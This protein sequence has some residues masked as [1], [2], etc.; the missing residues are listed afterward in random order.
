[1]NKRL[2]VVLN[3]WQR[4]RLQKIRDRSSSPRVG[5]RAVCLLLSAD[6]ASSRAI[7]QAT[8]LSLDAIT[9][10]RRRWHT[11]GCGS[12]ED[13]A[14]SG[15]PCRVTAAYRRQLRQALNRGPPAYGYLFTVWSIPRLNAHLT[16]RTGIAFCD[17][18]VRC[19]VLAED[20]VFRR[21]KHTLKGKRDEKAFRK[22]Q[23]ELRRLKKGPCGPV[24]ITNS[25]SRTRPSSTSTLI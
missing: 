20:Y 9:D 5:K 14:R 1:M 13:L 15:R 18:S 22:A 17:E 3:S 8:G 12:L 25:G 2:K 23:R 11:R 10:I 21:P 16:R 4:H 7:Q 6:G 19:L 24:P